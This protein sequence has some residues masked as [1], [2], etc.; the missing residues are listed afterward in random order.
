M[1][2][3][4]L[5]KYSRRKLKLL[6]GNCQNGTKKM[7]ESYGGLNWKEFGFANKYI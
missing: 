2:Y 3:K 5:Q 1:K 4:S 6:V 7:I